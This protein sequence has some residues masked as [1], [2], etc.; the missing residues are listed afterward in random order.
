MALLA[1][2]AGA[3][4][5]EARET[6]LT[7]FSGEHAL[8]LRYPSDWTTDQAEQG[9]VWYR[10]FLAPGGGSRGKPALAVTLLV[11]ALDGSLDE[12]ARTY[13]TGQKVTGSGDDQRPGARGKTWRFDSPD[14]ATR[15][16]LLLLEP[17]A[18]TAGS[19]GARRVYGLYAR[20]ESAAFE[21]QRPSLEAMAQSLTLERAERYPE[22]RDE[23]IG[24]ALRVPPSWPETRRFGGADAFLLQ[25][26]SPA[27]QADRAGVTVHATLTLSVEKLAEGATLEAFQE[28]SRGRLG[29]AWQLQGEAAWGAGAVDSLRAETALSATRQRRFYRVGAG[30]GYTLTCEARDDAFFRVARWCDL[31]AGTLL[32]RGERSGVTV[33]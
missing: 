26:S 2:C 12:Y 8:S 27:L 33:P 20:G 18:V 32:L 6:R 14:G 16:A 3:C 29:E 30:R 4:R 10:Y 23:K 1:C 22:T 25:W 7:Y 28:L 9:G 24:Y 17:D 21:Q 15:H 11:S 31:I 5:R 13:V 19:A